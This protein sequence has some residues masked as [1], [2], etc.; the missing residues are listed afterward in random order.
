MSGKYVIKK[1]RSK[2]RFDIVDENGE[3]VFKGAIGS[4]KDAVTRKI[5][6]M[7]SFGADLTNHL[8]AVEGRNNVYVIRGEE[9]SAREGEQGRVGDAIPLGF[10]TAQG[11][12]EEVLLT[13]DAILAACDGASVVDETGE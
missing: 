9:H 8:Q 12:R 2:Y 5:E 6:L 11:T 4:T 10:G 13:K 7:K 1:E 3:V